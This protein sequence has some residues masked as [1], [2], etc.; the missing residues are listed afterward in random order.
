MPVCEAAFIRKALVL[1][2]SIV[3]LLKTEKRGC[4]SL[5]VTVEPPSPAALRRTTGR[6]TGHT[7]A[8]TQTNGNET[9][10]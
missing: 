7:E 10:D 9:Q 2:G 8:E 1:L 4:G 5:V 3:F 6:Q